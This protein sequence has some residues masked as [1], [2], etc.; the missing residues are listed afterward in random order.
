[1]TTPEL[2]AVQARRKILPDEGW[3]GTG[4]MEEM[5]FQLGFEG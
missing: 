3:S 4:F 2:K 5:I 1:V